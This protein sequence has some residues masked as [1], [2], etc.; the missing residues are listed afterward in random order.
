LQAETRPGGGAQPLVAASH[1]STGDHPV[2]AAQQTSA[3][4]VTSGPIAAAATEP[5]Q[6]AA[7]SEQRRLAGTSHPA[8]ASDGPFENGVIFVGAAPPQ[9]PSAAFACCACC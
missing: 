4:A 6:A 1:T 8:A 2:T 3:E 7:V 9:R 5:G